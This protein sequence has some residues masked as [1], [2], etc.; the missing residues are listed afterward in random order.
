MAT[1]QA[2]FTFAFTFLSSL[3]YLTTLAASIA[4]DMS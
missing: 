1:N 2:H 4:L 3:T